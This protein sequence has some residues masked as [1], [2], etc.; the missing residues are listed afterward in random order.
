M[1]SLYLT[2]LAILVN[3]SR[4]DEGSLFLTPEFCPLKWTSYWFKQSKYHKSV[5]QRVSLLGRYICSYSALS[6]H[7]LSVLSHPGQMCE[8]IAFTWD[9]SQHPPF[10]QEKTSLQGWVLLQNGASLPWVPERG[11]AVQGGIFA[12][13]TIMISFPKAEVLLAFCCLLPFLCYDTVAVSQMPLQPLCR[14][15]PGWRLH[16]TGTFHCKA[17]TLI[18]L[19]TWMWSWINYLPINALASLPEKS[20]QNRL[21]SDVYLANAYK[22]PRDQG[23]EHAIEIS[24]MLLL[25][26]WSLT[27]LCVNKSWRGKAFGMTREH[28]NAGNVSSIY[29]DLNF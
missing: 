27:F 26:T 16:L 17:E 7:L 4:H 13:D 19:P 20:V 3:I 5:L 25:L 10:W 2:N 9:V 11:W 21:R 24:P 1:F 8:I 29:G 22:E 23:M 12:D 15:C 28:T 14:N 18:L 6:V